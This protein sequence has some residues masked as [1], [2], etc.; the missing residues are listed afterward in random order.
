MLGQSLDE[1]NPELRTLQP[2]GDIQHHKAIS[3]WF[4]P[5]ILA[6][7]VRI[8]LE[9][10]KNPD[11]GGQLHDPEPEDKKDSSN[12]EEDDPPSR[13][14]KPCT[15]LTTIVSLTSMSCSMCLQHTPERLEI[16]NDF[17][18]AKM[19]TFS[20]ET[21]SVV[22]PA[23]Q[24][25][26]IFFV[27]ACQQHQPPVLWIKMSFRFHILHCTVSFIRKDSIGYSLL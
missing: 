17:P 19:M 11:F 7:D 6:L 25:D 15:K 10:E 26:A 20:P 24:H 16:G 22:E 13:V 23:S 1:R 27:P 4:S 2:H 12:D 3:T 8:N 9:I 18:E 5:E 21:F 14:D